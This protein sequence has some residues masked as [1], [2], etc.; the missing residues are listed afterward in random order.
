M[1]TL[2]FFVTHV[3]VICADLGRAECFTLFLI[4]DMFKITTLKL[5]EVRQWECS[6][7]LNITVA[8]RATAFKLFRR[9]FSVRNCS[10]KTTR[11]KNVATLPTF[12][13]DNIEIILI[14]VT[15]KELFHI[16][17]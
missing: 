10:G 15:A 8:A 14:K 11:L 9:L 16:V 3:G 13:T 17:A 1:L 12:K 5:F 6:I 7:T 4:L 2:V